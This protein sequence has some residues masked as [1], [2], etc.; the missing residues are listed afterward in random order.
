RALHEG[1]LAG[2]EVAG[3][4]Q[5]V[6]GAERLGDGAPQAAGVLGRARRQPYG[7]LH[8]PQKSP[9]CS[10]TGVGGASAR[11]ALMDWKS[12]R[13]AWNCALDS[14]PPCRLAAGWNVGITTRPPISNR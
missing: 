11:M 1:G 10:S 14:P 6:A 5:H 13:S 3:Q 7:G 8:G 4:R 12:E 9:S 2:S